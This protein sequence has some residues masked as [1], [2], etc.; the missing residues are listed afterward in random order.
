MTQYKIEH[1]SNKE[2]KWDI[3]NEDR[4]EV[5]KILKEKEKQY[6]IKLKSDITIKTKDLFNLF[7]YVKDLSNRVYG[8]SDPETDEQEAS[9][10]IILNTIGYKDIWDI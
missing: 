8:K 1:P 9:L 6:K 4:S 10:G 5:I 2:N 7:E 3:S